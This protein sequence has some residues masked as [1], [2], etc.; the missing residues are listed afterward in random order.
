MKF[1]LI[2]FS[3]TILSIGTCF[4]QAWTT[5]PDIPVSLAFP[6]VVALDGNIHVIGGG[7][8]NGATDLHL[9]YRPS[10]N[11]WDT[12]SPVPYKAQQPGGAVVNGRIHYFGGGYPNSGTRLDDH[13][14]YDPSSNTW[15]KQQDMLIP[16]VIHKTATLGDT[17][18]ALSG[19]PD[20]SR[21]DIFTTSD[22]TWKR[23]NDLPDGNF[24]YSAMSVQ[25][26]TLYR[27]GGGGSISAV[28][29]AHVYNQ[30]TDT[31]TAVSSLSQTNHAPAAEVLGDS[32]YITGGYVD[33]RYS[34]QSLVYD[35]NT[36]S[37]GKGPSFPEG[38]SYHSMVRIDNCIYS[39]G[40]HNDGFEVNTSLIRYCL[41]DPFTNVSVDQALQSPISI[42]FGSENT[43]NVHGLQPGQEMLFGIYNL[44]GK[45]AWSET[46][47]KSKALTTINLPA[48]INGIYS[49][50]I[51]SEGRQY[52]F[53][54]PMLR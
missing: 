19:Q 54:L 30:K 51:E 22:S 6:V 25:N 4:S 1:T 35:V 24:W 34:D 7:G 38:R 10:T 50:V 8:P 32:L 26:N 40:G 48:L 3:T 20:K 23:R 49:V 5:L 17:I 53:K 52:W 31:W 47:F 33:Y 12:L 11:S 27:F 29:S 37:Y 45:L 46:T 44:E 9:R 39:V 14:A 41:G 43:L 18:Y 21:V 13:Y 28:T 16:R 2:F 42:S 15:L 36:Q